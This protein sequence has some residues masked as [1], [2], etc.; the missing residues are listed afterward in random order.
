MIAATAEGGG[1]FR[2]GGLSLA[3]ARPGR[4]IGDCGEAL[5]APRG[6]RDQRER[7]ALRTPPNA[8]AGKVAKVEFLG[9]FCMVGVQLDGGGAVPLIANVSRQQVDAGGITPGA[10]VTVSLP[11]AA[12]RILG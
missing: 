11:P 2:V 1:R 12:M 5:P 6:C 7:R 3:V 10:P 4:G 9:A 8:V